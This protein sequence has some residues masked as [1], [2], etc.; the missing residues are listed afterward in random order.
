MLQYH[1]GLKVRRPKALMM[2]IP[3]LV[4]VL[5]ATTGAAVQDPAAETPLK[6][7][8]YTGIIRNNTG[9]DLAIPSLNSG[10][11]LVVPAKGYIEYTVWSPNF[12]VDA[13]HDG[14]PFWCDKIKVAPDKYQYMC[15]KYDFIAEIKAEPVKPKPVPKKRHLK[16]KP[17]EEG[18][19]GLG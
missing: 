1:L 6:P 10:A 2:L 11:T 14:K 3:L 7:M 19:K 13:Y 9:Y 15:K 17:K 16:K 8:P 18:V 5:L 4:T 12:E